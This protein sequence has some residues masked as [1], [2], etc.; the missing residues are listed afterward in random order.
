MLAAVENNGLILEYASL[1]LTD[2]FDICLAAVEN[3]GLALKLA[4]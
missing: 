3:N 1:K 2:N 4:S